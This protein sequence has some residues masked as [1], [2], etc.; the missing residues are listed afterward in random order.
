MPND[1][2][3]RTIGRASGRSISEVIAV[4]VHLCCAAS[5]ATERGRTQSVC[6][7]NIA[8]AL[9]IST[10]DVDAI[11]KAMQGRVLDGDRLTGWEKR[12]PIREDGAAARSK[13]WREGKK[14]ENERNQTQ[15]NAVE[16]KQTLEEIREEKSINTHHHADVDAVTGFDAFWQKYPRKVGKAAALKAFQK[17]KPD[18]ALLQRMH[19]ALQ[20]QV[21]NVQLTK[22][23][24]QFFPHAGTWINGKRW[25]DEVESRQTSGLSK[26]G[27]GGLTALT[28]QGSN[29]RDPALVKIEGDTAKAVPP[30]AA[31]RAFTAALRGARS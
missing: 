17:L 8:S 19:S 5:N 30:P 28:V 15:S 14:S 25:E 20:G 6:S 3:W 4:F 18:D 10:D 12:Q 13:A 22:D 9:D 26:K 27:F 23:G 1:P 21:A 31:V 24:M 16:R 7:E 11:L 2:K 29:E